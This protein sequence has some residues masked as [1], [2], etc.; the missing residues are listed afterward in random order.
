MNKKVINEEQFKKLVI[1]EA[2]RL[3]SESK[4]SAPVVKKIETKPKRLTIEAV[5]NLIKEMEGLNTSINKLSLSI[6]DESKIELNN[7]PDTLEGPKRSLDVI[8][9]NKNKNINHVNENEKETWNRMM[10][11]KVPK[12]EDR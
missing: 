10:K 8:E 3:F 1:N 12:D 4:K 7:K 9:H 5:E 6:L 2:K 11:Y